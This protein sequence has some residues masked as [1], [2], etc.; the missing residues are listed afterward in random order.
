MDIQ[1]RVDAGAEFLKELIN[2]TPR[3]GVVLGSGLGDFANKLVNPIKVSYKD[4]PKFP[5]STI[6]GHAG[7]LYF[8]KLNEI[9]VVLMSGRLHY[10]EGYSQSEVTIPIRIMSKLGIETL[11]L[12]NAAGGINLE[13]TAGEL[14]LISDHINL[15]G[16]NP[17]IGPN[18]DEFGPRFP[19]MS[20]TYTKEL[21]Y[22]LLKS[23]KKES[24]DLKEGVYAMMSGPSFETPAEIK[25]LRRIGADAVGMSTVPEA[26]V[27]SHCG[28]KVIGISCITNMAAGV[29]NQKLSH[30]EVFETAN[31]V[32]SSFAQ[33]LE[34]AIKKVK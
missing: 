24:I 7:T 32:K 18:Q 9:P 17:L 2:E 31:R 25:Y 12:T 1:K 22:S 8:G 20:D 29:L 6:L 3:I 21:R 14:M 5:Q 27:A 28:L 11:I 23:A 26:I 10:Y 15:S 16:S 34:L 4:I 30:E 19:D 33:V 13:F